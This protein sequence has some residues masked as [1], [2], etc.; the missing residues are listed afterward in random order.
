METK[1]ALTHEEP[2]SLIQAFLR[3]IENVESKDSSFTGT[4]HRFTISFN[5]FDL[6]FLFLPEDQLLALCLD[7]FQGK[8]CNELISDS[9]VL[10]FFTH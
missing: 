6:L 3:E 2:K 1:N 8:Y 7:L 5:T 9:L 10:Q 4:I